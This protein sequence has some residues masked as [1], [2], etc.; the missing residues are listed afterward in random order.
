MYN[1]R[2][3]D[4][5][6][7]PHVMLFITEKLAEFD[8]KSVEWIKLLPLKKNTYYTENVVPYKGD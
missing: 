4:K 1:L 2:V 7:M 8:T 5:V 6:G 3:I